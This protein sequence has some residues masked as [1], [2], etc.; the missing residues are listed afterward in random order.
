MREKGQELKRGDSKWV[1]NPKRNICGNIR[2][3]S[4]NFM[5]S[6]PAVFEKSRRQTNRRTHRKHTDTHTHIVGKG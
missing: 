3:L 4:K 6:G 2:I 1:K 5:K